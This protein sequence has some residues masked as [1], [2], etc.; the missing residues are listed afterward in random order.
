MATKSTRALVGSLIGVALFVALTPAAA[1]AQEG[2]DPTARRLLTE[3]VGQYVWTRSQLA[4][5]LPPLDDGRSAWSTLL[6]RRYLASAIRTARPPVRAGNVFGAPVDAWLRALIAERVYALD[7]EGLAGWDEEIAVDV[8]VYEPLPPW[9]LGPVPP[10]IE[11]AL[12]PL[13]PAVEYRMVS[14]ALILWD[15]DAE[16]VIDV[17]PHAFEGH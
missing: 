1:R 10:E 5:P 9:A 13:P 15:A 12:P 16:I 4:A 17:L 6:T 2:D 14:G 3:R 7:V 11:A 8:V